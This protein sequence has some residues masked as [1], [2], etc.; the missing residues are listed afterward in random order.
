MSSEDVA[1]L[2]AVGL[3][4]LLVTIAVVP[5]ASLW[6]QRRYARA[7]AIRMGRRP[8]VAPSLAIYRQRHNPTGRTSSKSIPIAELP[9]PPGKAPLLTKEPPAQ[10]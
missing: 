7:V 8:L 3:P 10:S 2:A 9:Y 6:I 5:L 4:A 1:V